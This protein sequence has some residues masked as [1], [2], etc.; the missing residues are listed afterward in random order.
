VA[1][2]KEKRGGLGEQIRA[3]QVLSGEAFGF[4]TEARA[5]A[6][7]LESIG[8]FAEVEHEACPLCTHQLE[9]PVP[10]ARAIRAS[11]QQLRNSLAATERERP[12]L[13][14][15]VEKL[16]QQM[17]ELTDRQ[18]EKENAILT[19]QN[20]E[21]AAREIRDLNSRRAKVTGRIS[22]YVESVPAPVVD[23]QLARE[24]ESARAKVTRLEAMLD[25]VQKEQRLTSILNRVSVR[26]TDLAKK[27][28]LEFSQYP[29]RLDPSAATIVADAPERPV[30][31]LLI[32]SGENWLGYHL[33]AHLALHEHFR[34]HQRPVPRFLFLD[35]P[36]QV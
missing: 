1:I 30:P 14:E 22:L 32:G 31:L 16:Q 33:A 35:Q 17:I 27:L 34:D 3:A 24:I 4:A 5:Q 29:V 21:E 28:R 25:P 26:I 9:T 8:L 11:L 13:R 12:R 10:G 20:Q 7:R 23:N 19:L 2:L 18:C 36:S 15:Y 6:E